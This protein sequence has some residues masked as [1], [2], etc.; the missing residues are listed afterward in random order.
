M[1][2]RTGGG[3]HSKQVHRQGMH[4]GRPRHGK[5][6]R[7]VSQ[8]GAS[9]GNHVTEHLHMLSKN[10][11][12]EKMGAG[13]GTPSELG[14]SVAL[15]VGAGGPGKGRA[16]YGSGTQQTHGHVAGNPRPAGRDILAGFGPEIGGSLG[17]RRR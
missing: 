7:A 5:N 14:N 1:A 17:G 6:P 3:I 8:I 15:N 11:V 16:V 12:V 13:R 9:L 4:T 2:K 10:K